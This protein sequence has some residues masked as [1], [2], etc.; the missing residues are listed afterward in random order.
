MWNIKLYKY[1]DPISKS[2][3]E[4]TILFRK[5]IIKIILSYELKK[6]KFFF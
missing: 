1:K 5:Y 2:S 6:E 4:I 3:P